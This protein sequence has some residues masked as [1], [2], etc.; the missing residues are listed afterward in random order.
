PCNH[1]LGLLSTGGWF[2]FADRRERRI[3]M[4]H[5][6]LHHP[7]PKVPW[8]KRVWNSFKA[9]FPGRSSESVKIYR[10]SALIVQDIVDHL[11]SYL[12]DTSSIPSFFAVGHLQ[13]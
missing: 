5:F 8:W 11:P 2:S 13:P 3:F 6:H 4:S 1:P 7:P 12:L 10:F 9:N